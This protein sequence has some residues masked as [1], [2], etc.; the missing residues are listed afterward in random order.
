MGKNKGH[1]YEDM[2]FELLEKTGL[3]YPK[4]K[5]EGMAGGVDAVFCHLGK[6]YNLEVKNGL[7]ADYGQTFLKWGKDGWGWLGDDEASRFF[8]QRGALIY[9]RKKGI[10]PIKYN[11]LKEKLTF[12]DMHKDQ[13]AFEDA[14]FV[15]KAEA[16]WKYYSAK[17]VHYIQIGSGYGFYHLDADVAK[18]GTQQFTDDL[19]L[20]FR[21]KCHNHYRRIKNEKGEVIKKIPTPWNYSFIAVLKVKSKPKPK[22]SKYN[23]EK[24]KDQDFPPIKP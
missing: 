17:D 10:V 20:R 24:N 19:I 22:R 3:L 2:I 1:V 8:D 15:V 13:V 12:D 11:K 21:A 16:L 7:D 5:H 6:P 4:T 14:T 18:L 9:L 23:I